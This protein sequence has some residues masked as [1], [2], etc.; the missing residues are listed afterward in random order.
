MVGR[1]VEEAFADPAKILAALGLERHSGA[2]ARMDEEIVAELEA[3]GHLVE[4]IT[5]GSGDG[6]LEPFLDLAGGGVQGPALAD[7]VAFAA[8]VTA[9]GQP[10]DDR[11]FLAVEHPEEE[12]LV[13]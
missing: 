1:I 2:D 4:E 12:F 5:V 10:V 9:I 11:V 8:L 7:A 3:V 6:A 13:I